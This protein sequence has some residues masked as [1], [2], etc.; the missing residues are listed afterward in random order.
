VK[1]KNSSQQAAA[2][3]HTGSTTAADH[4]RS[5]APAPSLRVHLQQQLHDQLLL[6]ATAT[7]AMLV[8]LCVQI[9]QTNNNGYNSK[10][11]KNNIFLM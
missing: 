9:V 7:L 1:K 3:G 2:P 4:S 11:K 8:L 5:S 6:A 10:G